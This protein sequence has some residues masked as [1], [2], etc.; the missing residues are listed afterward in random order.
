MYLYAIYLQKEN[1]TAN[2]KREDVNIFRIENFCHSALYEV[3][4]LLS[5][6]I[7]SLTTLFVLI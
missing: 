1:F 2:Q 3:L 6:L 7:A 4:S 5:T